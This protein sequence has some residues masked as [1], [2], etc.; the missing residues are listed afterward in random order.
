M[1]PDTRVEISGRPV[2]QEPMVSIRHHTLSLLDIDT[3]FPVYHSELGYEYQ[4]RNGGFGTFD[5]PY[6]H[7]SGLYPS[8]PTSEQHQHRL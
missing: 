8:V 6:N 7:E 5:I 3:T 4:L 2:P 1:G